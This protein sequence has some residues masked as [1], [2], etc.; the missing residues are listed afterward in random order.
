MH[1]HP[2]ILRGMARARHIE[3][4]AR[5]VALGART[6]T[7]RDLRFAPRRRGGTAATVPGAVTSPAT[8]AED[9]SAW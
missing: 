5:G 3:A 7:R 9:R 6:P 4:A 2:E 8:T 1:V